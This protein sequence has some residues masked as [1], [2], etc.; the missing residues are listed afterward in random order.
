M[1]LESLDGI[2]LGFIIVNITV[3][4]NGEMIG[5]SIE[6]PLPPKTLWNVSVQA[7]GCEADTVVKGVELSKSNLCMIT[8]L[9][10]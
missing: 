4:R 10:S 3:E 7:Y 5:M 8:V 1:T 9:K 2:G 6:E